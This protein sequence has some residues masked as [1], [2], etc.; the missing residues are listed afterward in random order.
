[1]CSNLEIYSALT[2]KLC[3]DFVWL[4]PGHLKWYPDLFSLKAIA[5]SS[6]RRHILNQI[7]FFR[8]HLNHKLQ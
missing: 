6:E 4:S 3:S 2:D 1:M 7:G 5:S 8:Y